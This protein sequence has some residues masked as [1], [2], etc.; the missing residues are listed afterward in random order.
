MFEE[1]SVYMRDRNSY[2]F[3]GLGI[4][5]EV[6]RGD[7][8]VCQVRALTLRN[9][10]LRADAFIPSRQGLRSSHPPVPSPE[11]GAPL[12]GAGEGRGRGDERAGSE[13]QRPHCPELWDGRWGDGERNASLEGG[14]HT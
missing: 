4:G 11:S 8:H 3:D 9:A 7:W 14:N 6:V 13:N 12:S 5:V 10:P 1:A 2:I